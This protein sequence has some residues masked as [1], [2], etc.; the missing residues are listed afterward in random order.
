M[1]FDKEKIYKE[2][3]SLIIMGFLIFA[4][5]ST[6]FEPFR[7]PTGSMVPT[8]SI[9]D[10]IVTNKFSYGFKLPYSDM[11][12]DP[13]YLTEFK[14][15]KRN[16]IIVFKYPLE[17]SINYVKRVIGLPGDE[18]ELI[19]KEVFINGK[20]IN[21]TLDQSSEVKDFLQS[22]DDIKLN[23]YKVKDE[24]KEFYIQ[25]TDHQTRADTIPR[26]KVPEGKY[27]AM[28]DNR[29]FSADS[30]YWGFVPKEN[31][32]GKAM[33]V[34]MSM[35]LPFSKEGFNVQFRRIGHVL[36]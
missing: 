15:P 2:T 19:N 5:R 17:P 4:F 1:N 10:F 16:D 20:S 22:F 23:F 9:G 12:W 14:S 34:W 18:I 36:N 3:K 11:F 25:T 21:V 7:V 24:G 32:K 30:R 33:F 29:D 8:I 31:I 35:T 28:G 6:F 26:F 13:I 27:F